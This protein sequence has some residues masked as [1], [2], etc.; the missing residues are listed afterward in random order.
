MEAPSD[1][2]Y[3][4]TYD[5]YKYYFEEIHRLLDDLSRRQGELFILLSER[6]RLQCL[7]HYI[8]QL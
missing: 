1:R 8:E 6:K 3:G 7:I 4:G 2:Y 5:E